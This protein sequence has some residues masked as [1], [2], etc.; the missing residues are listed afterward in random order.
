M[1]VTGM[2]LLAL[3]WS[4]FVWAGANL[5]CRL[6]PT[7]RMAQAI[8]RGA[9]LM[10]L[11]PFAAS[12]IVPGLPRTVST[13]IPDLPH[14]DPF[15]VTPQIVDPVVNA[16][17][18]RLPDTAT[19]LLGLLVAGW[20]VRF[21]IWGISQFRL[22]RLKA[23]AR[24]AP[25]PVAH[26]AEAM[27]LRHV[28]EIRVIPQGTPFLAGVLKRSVYL[29]SAL[30][31]SD[32]A[33]PVI[34]HELVHLKRGDLLTRPFERL[35]ADLFWFSPFAWAMRRELDFWREAVTDEVAADLTGDRIA[36][37]RALTRAARLSRPVTTLPVAAFILKPEGSLKMRLNQLLT[38][39]RRSRRLGLAVAAALTCA[40]PL[41]LAQGAVIKGE[42][43]VSAGTLSYVHAVLDE[44]R[45]T[46][47]YGERIH[48]ISKKKAF[49][50]GI[51][52]AA[53][54]GAP[55]YAPT[56]GTVVFAKEKGNY[57]NLVELVAGD[58]T[59]F[60]FAQLNEMKVAEGDNVTGGQVL[61]TVGSS[62]VSTGPHLHLEVWR[63]GETI[64][65]QAEE[66][67]I[68][69]DAFAGAKKALEAPA[70][71]N[72]ASAPDAPV[73]EIPAACD[74]LKD[75]NKESPLPAEWKVR[76][77]A[78]RT[79]NVAAGLT[80][81]ANW[82]PETLSYPVPVYPKV[83][84]EAD[85]MAMCEVLFDLGTEGLPKNAVARC[86]DP[87][88]EESAAQLPKARFASMQDRSGQPVE[89]KGIRYPL[90]YCIQ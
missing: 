6:G 50:A 42:A 8:W 7:P 72:P 18:L 2:L 66:G 24:I 31:N 9:A 62:G 44:A 36:Y 54:K 76:L 34:V 61:G 10:L 51:D 78:A 40:A 37:A 64:D 46:S 17:I 21:A 45:I 75:W 14:L 84:A 55:V 19:L 90:Q 67:L 65:P 57:G 1:S 79:T 58:G 48:P 13:P 23:R 29:P 11:A 82:A 53:S 39:P 16:P 38:Q 70:A 12:F 20:A 71:L 33:G 68:L 35:V 52:L 85:R 59:T 60:R 56:A 3:G 81:D 5:V 49:H 22:Q 80:I 69:A 32:A 25:R 87:G 28:P 30:L 26:W 74:A 73:R 89:V 63:G 88:F 77:E 86:S 47:T 15:L 4:A 41:A 27:D 43:G 83:A